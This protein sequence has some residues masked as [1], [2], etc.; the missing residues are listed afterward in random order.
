ML[1]NRRILDETPVERLFIP[2]APGDSGGALG[3]ALHVEH[4]VLGNP[5]RTEL[6]HAYWGAEYGGADIEAA[7][8]ERPG[9]VHR[10]PA[11]EREVLDAT[12]A[13]LARGEVVGWFQGRFELG[14]R[15]LGDRSIIADPRSAAMK[16]RINEKIK[17]REPFRPFAPAAK[18]K[19]CW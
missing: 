16:E 10:R 6:E 13:A 7:L 8:R 17:F 15:A 4:V 19:R 1:A 2:P 9:V 14:P 3:A 11:D 18:P 12:V 5:R